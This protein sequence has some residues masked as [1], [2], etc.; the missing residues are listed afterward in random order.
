ADS[1]RDDDTYADE[2]N[3]SI[4]TAYVAPLLTWSDIFQ[5]S[6]SF[7]ATGEARRAML[8][9]A[10]P[11]ASFRNDLLAFIKAPAARLAKAAL[12]RENYPKWIAAYP[13]RM[14]TLPA[15]D[16][17]FSAERVLARLSGA[18]RTSLES[19]FR[20]NL[21]APTQPAA[22]VSHYRSQWF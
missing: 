15:A 17:P 16:T 4:D 11:S 19:Y 6:Q 21:E 3:R 2:A 13:G 9:I 20:L 1:L 22:L 7:T 12:W 14:E 8:A 10:F 5:Y 18:Q